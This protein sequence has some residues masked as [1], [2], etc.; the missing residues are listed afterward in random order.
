MT[1]LGG[2]CELCFY[3]LF[4]L[5]VF[6]FLVWLSFFMAGMFLVLVEAGRR[7]SGFG[8]SSEDFCIL[9]WV[10]AWA[11]AIVFNSIWGSAGLRLEEVGCAPA[12]PASRP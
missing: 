6:G 12:R 11:V 3:C 1:F 4:V 8:P 2:L 7:M 10:L 5:G 9:V